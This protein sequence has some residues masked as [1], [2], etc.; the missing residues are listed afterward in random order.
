[1]GKRKRQV[2]KGRAESRS[3]RARRAGGSGLGLVEVDLPPELLA[4]ID[5]EAVVEAM[6]S[7][8][9]ICAE[10]RQHPA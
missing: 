9:P 4:T 5:V 3:Q 6:R 8:C 7:A 1:M 10:G 2:S